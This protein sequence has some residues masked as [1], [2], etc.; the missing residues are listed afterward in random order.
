MELTIAMRSYRK[1]PP[2]LFEVPLTELGDFRLEN[3]PPH[4]SVEITDLPSSSKDYEFS[5][6]VT[7]GGDKGDFE[8]LDI[9]GFVGFES[10]DQAERKM[11]RIR[12]ALLPLVERGCLPD[13]LVMPRKLGTPTGAG[14]T[15]NCA[16]RPQTVVR[17]VIQ[18]LLDL[19]LKLARP[20]ARLFVCH[21][22]EDKGIA[23]ELAT[24]LFSHGADVWLDE[25]EIRVGDSI[26]TKISEGLEA[27]SHLAVLLSKNSVTKPW[28]TRELSSALMRQI[29]DNAVSVLPIRLDDSHVPAI[30]ADIRYA[31]CRTDLQSGFQDVVNAIFPTRGGG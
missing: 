26:V 22:S 24:F 30:L 27:S 9:F 13:P 2:G 29:K 10:G 15:I 25:W 3:I 19:F 20:E 23:R 31:D 8:F 12:R 11:K 16:D 18:P 21:A 28:V 5:I 4:E 1:V 14:F 6:S 7:N 17:E